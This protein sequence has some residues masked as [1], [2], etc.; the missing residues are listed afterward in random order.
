MA[1][2]VRA[3]ALAALVR[4]ASQGPAR[5][6]LNGVHVATDGTM[7]ATDGHR[8]LR[9]PPESDADSM[10]K[11]FPRPAGSK[12]GGALPDGGVIL[13]PAL[14]AEA[15]KLAPK[16]HRAEVLADRV[17][18]A[19]RGDKVELF[20]TDL[21]TGR[22]LAAKPVEGA[23]PDTEQVIPK[24]APAHRIAVDLD[25]LAEMLAAM[26]AAGVSGGQGYGVILEFHGTFAA[27]GMRS[28]TTDGRDV[29]GLLMPLRNAE[30]EAAERARKR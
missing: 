19:M 1:L 18:L 13:P 30:L 23:Y 10:A 5:P 27:M 16:K 29:Y 2:I 8:L 14:A 25:Y 11:D 20:G 4:I 7:T 6:Q 3:S 9:V 15:V 22:T 28:R 24:K 26:K 21:D 17:A 12:P